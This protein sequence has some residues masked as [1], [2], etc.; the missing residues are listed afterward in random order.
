L[1]CMIVS[2]LSLR[3]HTDNSKLEVLDTHEI[4]GKQRCW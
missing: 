1:L 2:K 4:V 3:F